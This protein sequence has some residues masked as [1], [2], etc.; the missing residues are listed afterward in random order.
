MS[1]RATSTRRRSPSDSEP[2]RCCSRPAQPKRSSSTSARSRSAPVSSSSRTRIVPVAPPSMTSSTLVQGSNSSTR[3]PCTKPMRSRSSRRSTRPRRPPSTVTRARVGVLD[4][5]GEQ[6]QAGL[7]RAVRA[8]HDP[9]LARPRRAGRAAPARC[10]AGACRDGRAAPSP[11]RARSPPRRPMVGHAIRCRACTPGTGCTPRAVQA[12]AASSARRTITPARWRL[13]SVEP[14]RSAS[15]GR[16]PRP[17]ARRRRRPRRPDASAA[18][19]PRRAHGRRRRR[20]TGRRASRPAPFETAAPMQR[21]V[22][23]VA[24]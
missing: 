23:R 19:T 7:A 16:C 21:P 2:K 20:R 9:V 15:A 24:G 22:R 10:A 4:G 14:P 13:Y 17:R 11:P 1:A 8:Q 18:S 5:R 6:Q 12:P 3:R